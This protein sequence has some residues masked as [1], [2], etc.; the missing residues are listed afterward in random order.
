VVGDGQLGATV[1][2]GAGAARRQINEAPGQSPAPSFG[3]A[4]G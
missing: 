3:T 2:G 1:F 4:Q